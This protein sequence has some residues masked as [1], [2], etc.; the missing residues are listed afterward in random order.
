[1]TPT[2]TAPTPT[3]DAG[4][5]KARSVTV[6]NVSWGAYEKLVEAFAETRSVRL[7]YDREVLEIMVPSLN[8]NFSDRSLLAFVVFLAK[9]FG[10]GY[11][12][13]GQTTMK[14]KKLLKGAEADEIFWIANA[15]AMAGVTDL[16]LTVHPPPDLAIEVDVTRSSAR[17]MRV[18]AAIGIP[19]VWR[20]RG[21]GLTF[22]GLVGKRYVEIERSRS[23]PLLS[24]ADLLAFLCRAWAG[25]NHLALYDEVQAWARERAR[26]APAAGGEPAA[27]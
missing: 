16:D 6:R 27:G 13:G 10:T 18:L 26:T 11:H 4:R 3:P 1:M 22:L 25:G 9:G 12:P 15:P 17:R 23:F 7:T 24:A 2:P 21:D 8:H 20:Q 19:E 5:R 14:R